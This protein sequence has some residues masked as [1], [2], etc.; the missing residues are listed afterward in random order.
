M[1][2]KGFSW[3]VETFLGKCSDTMNQEFY[4]EI[5]TIEKNV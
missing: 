1:N 4:E 3:V 5:S 2:F